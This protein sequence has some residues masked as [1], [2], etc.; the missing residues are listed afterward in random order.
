MKKFKGF[1]LIELIIVMAIFTGIAVGAMA[2]IKPVMKLF[3]NTAEL[4]KSSADA[5]NIRRY[6]EDNLRY[7]N[8]LFNCVGYNL[9]LIHIS[10]PTRH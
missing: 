3:N 4:E 7:A 5:D 8:R 9:S 1:T 6:I 2:M 10:E